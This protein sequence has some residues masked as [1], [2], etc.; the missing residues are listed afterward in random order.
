MTWGVAAVG[1]ELACAVTGA[2]SIRPQLATTPA[3]SCAAF[4]IIA[5]LDFPSLGIECPSPPMRLGG[6]VV[7]A[8]LDLTKSSRPFSDGVVEQCQEFLLRYRLTA[9]PSLVPP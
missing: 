8:D 6:A 5:R 3:V 2:A 1:P 4:F 9:P 7:C